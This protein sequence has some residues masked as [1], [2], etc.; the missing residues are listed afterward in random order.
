MSKV[1]REEGVTKVAKREMMFADLE[2]KDL[3]APKDRGR[4]GS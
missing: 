2:D 3:Q 1:N 4:Q